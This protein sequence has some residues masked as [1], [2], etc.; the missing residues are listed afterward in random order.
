MDPRINWAHDF[1]AELASLRNEGWLV[2]YEVPWKS[3]SAGASL[4]VNWVQA[5]HMYP[6]AILDLLDVQGSV[7]TDPFQR[8]AWDK[9]KAAVAFFQEFPAGPLGL[10][11][12]GI[13]LVSHSGSHF[14]LL[15]VGMFL[16]EAME[17]IP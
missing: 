12:I 14:P 9:R 15:P 4:A 1:P 10:H 7:P 5:L 13:Y 2:E 17:A 8:K 16:R 3:A 11:D 6:E